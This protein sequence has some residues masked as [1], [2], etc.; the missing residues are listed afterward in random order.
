MSAI[1]ISSLDQEVQDKIAAYRARCVELSKGVFREVDTKW[2]IGVNWSSGLEPSLIELQNQPDWDAIKLAEEEF[3]LGIKK[4]VRQI[5]L[6][7]NELADQLGVTE[8]YL[9]DNLFAV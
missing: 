2:K 9:W 6:F 7:C 8:N 5:V 1:D 4:E 3:L